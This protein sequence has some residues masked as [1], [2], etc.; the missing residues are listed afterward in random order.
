[1]ANVEIIAVEAGAEGMRLDRWLLERYPG[2]GHG[3]IQKLMRTGQV[4]LD[5]KRVKPN[6]RIVAGQTVRVP[7][8]VNVGGH[9][10]TRERTP[11]ST[12]DAGF[13]RSLVIHD[14][15]AIVALNKPAGLAI[16]GGSK[17][18]RHVDAML[19]GLVRA[20]GERPRLVHRLD[21]DTSGVVVLARTREAARALG[22][23]FMT[24][25]V[26]KI[27]WALVRGTP[28]PVAA[29]IAAPL[30]K[31]GRRGDQRMAVADTGDD[32]AQHAVT[33]YRVVDMAGTRAA[34]VALAPRTGRTHQLRAHMAAI[35]HPILGD[36][37]YGGAATFISDEMAPRL[38][39]HARAL[40]LPHPAG[41]RLRLLADLPRHMHEGFSVLGFKSDEER[42]P[43]A[44][45]DR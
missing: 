27:Y 20:G 42:D 38:H 8:L 28:R 29:T 41:H 21:R 12:D 23:A 22:R 16:Q 39:L 33:D 9:K 3:A 4:R 17:T 44:G 40:E 13:I 34:W 31:I 35:G 36:G 15:E 6:V 24:R 7:P 25:D 18:S 19:D 26:L 1:M 30:K 37:K 2:L 14:D 32:G 45:F 11:V 10:P 5:G 43:F